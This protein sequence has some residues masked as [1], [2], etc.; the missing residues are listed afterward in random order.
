MSAEVK[1]LIEGKVKEDFM[2]MTGEEH[3]QPTV[4]LVR[5]GNLIMVVDPGIL[6]SQQVL[7]D[8]LLKEGLTLGD[9]NMV[10]ITH[11]HLDHYRNV[12]MFSNARILEYYG[13]WNGNSVVT[14]SE[15][16]TENI[17]AVHTPGHDYSSITLFV[18]TGQES[19]TPGVVAICGDVFWRKGYME[20]VYDDVFASNPEKL[21]DSRNTVLNMADWII[22]G[23]GSVY[24]NES[25]ISDGTKVSIPVKKIKVVLI[26]KRCRS[27]MEQRDKCRCRPYLC[28]KCCE[29][30]MDCDNCNC[31]HRR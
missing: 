5:D 4:T 8:A 28:F 19:Q 3:T 16:I 12:G 1:I 29:C 24:K 9:V 30:G 13:I 26:C 20:D 22:P 7:I 15:K 14:W 27:K 18:K 25:R 23:H 2:S 6:P 21:K 31:S 11:S 17:K 10:C